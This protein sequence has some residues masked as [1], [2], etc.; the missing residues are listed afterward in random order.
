MVLQMT[1]FRVPRWYT[2]A[3]STFLEDDSRIQSDSMMVDALAKDQLKGLDH[4]N[5]Y[6][7]T[8]PLMAYVHG[9]YVIEYI[10]KTFGFDAHLK[11]IK[12]FGQGKKVSEALPEATGKTLQELDAGQLAYLKEAYAKVRLRPVLDK[13]L[14]V[15]LE[16]AAN[17]D[18]ASAQAL[19]DLAS[20]RLNMR[21]FAAA[22]T[23]AQKA[24]AKDPKC[25]DAIAIL[26]HVAYERNDLEAAKQ[27]YIEAT[28][29]GPERVVTAWLRLASIYKK[30][31]KTTKAIEAFEAARKNYPRYVGPDNPCHALP[32]LYA[33]LE[34]P[35]LDKAL[36]VWRDAVHVNPEDDEAALKGLRL[37][38]KMK[39]FVAA[40]EFA[41]A[42]VE[43]D[44]Y[45]V[46]AHRLGGQAFMETKDLVHAA[47]EFGAATALDDKDV[48]SWVALARARKELG[49][50]DGARK[51]V[52]Q[53]LDVDGTHKE[54]KALRD[55]LK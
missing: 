39:D 4:I 29:I 20:A 19:A 31:G 11:A 52:N 25:V 34:P 32:D 26:G 48:D 49:Q 46:E 43:V 17:K 45:N 6:F 22:E 51:A 41:R 27:R 5:D 54:A 30:E 16:V 2:E 12:L 7:R 14:I 44:P 42:Y 36:A 40:Q 47:R 35:Q 55:A 15:Q 50:L 1:Q 23:L 28:G 21:N 38:S 33:E 9:R 18:D 8:N 24:L 37:A 10:D 3:F 53:A 13:T